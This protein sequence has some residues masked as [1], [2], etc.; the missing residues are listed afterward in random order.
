MSTPF[1]PPPSPPLPVS[2]PSP[3]HPGPAHS[4]AMN[5]L[6]SSIES[7]SNDAEECST[8]LSAES[9][10][11]LKGTAVNAAELKEFRRALERYSAGNGLE[12]PEFYED[13]AR[14]VSPGTAKN[15][16]ARMT[17]V[18]LCIEGE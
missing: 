5:T 17:D 6:F 3:N 4:D 1:T 2:G 14:C 10:S 7:Q 18:L 15:P 12:V 8:K 9:V 13:V 11:A 16:Q